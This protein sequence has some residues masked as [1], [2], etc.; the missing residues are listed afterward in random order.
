MGNNQTETNLTKHTANMPA[1]SVRD[2]S[3]EDLTQAIHSPGD[4]EGVL[5]RT[6]P[7]LKLYYDPQMSDED[8]AA[9]LDEF[10]RALRDVPFWAVSQA[11]DRWVKSRGRRPSPGEIMELANS[12]LSRYSTELENRRQRAEMAAQ[13]PKNKLAPEDQR[14]KAEAAQSI[15][16]EAGFDLKRAARL[17]LNRM[18]TTHDEREQDKPARPLHWTKTADPDG[19]EMKALHKEREGYK[20]HPKVKSEGKEA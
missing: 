8:R 13:K 11:F 17:S 6:R 10:G 4:E 14:V 9:M 18:A 16:V 20:V 3:I 12:E 2:R 1:V 7:V 15:L 5:N 19:P